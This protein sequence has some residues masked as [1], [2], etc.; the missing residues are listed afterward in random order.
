MKIKKSQLK[1]IIKEELNT[2]IEEGLGDVFDALAFPGE[3]E[4]ERR[5]KVMAMSDEEFEE[6]K[7]AMADR[8]QDAY[9]RKAGF[10]QPDEEVPGESDERNRQ[11]RQARQKAQY[12]QMTRSDQ[13][14]FDRAVRKARRRRELGQDPLPGDE[15]YLALQEAVLRRVLEL[16]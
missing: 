16:I 13:V 3:T 12:D 10:L 9:E 15:R 1:Q 5:R 4:L 7:Q 8:E 6:L 11:H 2:E 14:A